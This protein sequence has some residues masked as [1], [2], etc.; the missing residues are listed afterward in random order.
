MSEEYISENT[1][2]ETR[3]YSDSF[4]RCPLCYIESKIYFKVKIA[5][6]TDRQPFS[7]RHECKFCKLIFNVFVSPDGDKWVIISPALYRKKR[8]EDEY[9][10]A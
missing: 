3:Y 6:P 9:E 5:R 10:R 4:V 2:P 7:Y 1:L 8:A